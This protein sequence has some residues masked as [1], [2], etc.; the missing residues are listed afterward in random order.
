MTTTTEKPAESAAGPRTPERFAPAG[1]PRILAHYTIA[2]LGLVLRDWSFIAFVLAMPVS[3]YLFFAGI[4]G[5]EM[6]DNGT[7]VA[8]IMMATM[9]TYGGLGAAM[10]AGN[11]I[12]T[13]RTTGWFRQ[14]MLT[15]L[16]PA[17]FVVGK[18]VTAVG[19]VLPAIGIVFVAG[20]LRGVRLPLSTWAV[21][22]VLITLA[23]LPMVLLGLVLGLW[24]RPTAAGA[25]TTLT[26]LALS[27]VG[28]LWFP[29]DMMPAVMQTVG[30][31]LPSYW[32]GQLGVW[33]IGGG[34]FPW[35]GVLV[36]GCWTVGLI[37]VGALGYGRA[38]RSSRR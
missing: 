25:A 27:M 34:A 22:F 1:S 16:T 4:Y 19:V 33:P 26:M 15:G 13:E 35:R 10:S 2:S 8:A 11:Q 31:L 24:L 29:L 5:H 28:G 9:A 21:S 3:I 36:I 6:S 12:Q 20:A 37:V 38:V 14:L 23:L 18:I 30:R 32:A 17:Q 7:P